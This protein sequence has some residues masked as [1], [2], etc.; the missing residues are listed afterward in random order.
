MEAVRANPQR[1]GDDRLDTSRGL[2][3]T[4]FRSIQNIDA[5]QSGN[6]NTHRFQPIM[7]KKKKRVHLQKCS[8]VGFWLEERDRKKHTHTKR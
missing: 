8:V 3:D 1:I 7:Y 2:L 6:E 5:K 4:S